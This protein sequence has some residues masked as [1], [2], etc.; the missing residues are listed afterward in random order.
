MAEILASDLCEL[1]PRSS[2][3]FF[4]WAAID[5]TSSRARIS[6]CFH[7]LCALF[8]PL[9]SIVSAP[10]AFLLPSQGLAL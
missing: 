5:R 9:F 6:D 3:G 2:A 10:A 4:R 8:F 7:L 1:S